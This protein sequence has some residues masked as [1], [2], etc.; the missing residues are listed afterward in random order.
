ME[1]QDE[2]S[3][4][5]IAISF[6]HDT[7]CVS[8][9]TRTGFSIY[10][11][12]PALEKRF[13]DESEGVRIVE[14]LYV[15]SLLAVVG[16]GDAPFS[17]PRKLRLWNSQKREAIYD[18]L[19]PSAVLSVRMNLE[20]LVACC[21]T[22]IHIFE[23]S[24]MSCIQILTTT[25]NPNGLVVLSDKD[26]QLLAFPHGNP[27]DV[28]IYDC[29]APRLMGKITAHKTA[30]VEMQFN[31]SGTLLAT[32][33][34]TGTVIRVFSVPS[35]EKLYSFRRGNRPSNITSIAFSPMSDLVAVGS[36]SGT[37][38][39]FSIE[40]AARKGSGAASA[41]PLPAPSSGSTGPLTTEHG[42]SQSSDGSAAPG[43]WT[44]TIRSSTVSVIGFVQ[45]WS[46]S[47]VSSLNVLPEDMQEFADSCRASSLARIP[48]AEG[49]FKAAITSVP[50]TDGGTDV[51]FKLVV[52]TRNGC[53]YRFSIPPITVPIP[54]EPAMCTLEDEA[55]LDLSG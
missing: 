30:V 14:M 53:Y 13:S 1:R 20:R 3:E 45:N 43:T 35:G 27:G 39:I 29:L 4:R 33:S 11:L 21:E 6:N 32:A 40:A 5:V 42:A 18:N 51:T 37:V 10:N 25:S 9:G 19:F 50:A 16:S 15:T 52:I 46:F 44:D 38:H 36:S 34:T 23:L 54:V 12:T 7:S 17:N 31:R 49:N 28:V 41:P 22:Q 55:L 8:I 47:T 48:G 26:T 2:R 24:L